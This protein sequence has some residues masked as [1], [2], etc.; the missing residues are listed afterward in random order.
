MQQAASYFSSLAARNERPPVKDTVWPTLSDAELRTLVCQMQYTITQMQAELE[1]LRQ[2]L[3][4]ERCSFCI[5]SVSTHHGFD[6]LDVPLNKQTAAYLVAVQA[7][8]GCDAVKYIRQVLSEHGITDAAFKGNETTN[9]IVDALL[10]HK[11]SF[12]MVA[13]LLLPVERERHDRV[14][15]MLMNE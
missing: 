14:L 13:E 6:V 4:R 12:G 3:S 7:E 11:F 2:G 10:R 8:F 9:D 5:K 1:V 15:A